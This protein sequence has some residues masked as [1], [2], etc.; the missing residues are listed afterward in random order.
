VP[1]TAAI[2]LVLGAAALF[3]AGGARSSE[4]SSTEDLVFLPMLVLTILGYATVGAILASRNPRH[5]IGWIMLTIGLAF[6]FSQIAESYAAYTLRIDRGALP[7]GSV[8]AWIGT[9]IY[10]VIFAALPLLALLYPSGGVVGPRW[11]IVVWLVLASASAAALG[12]ALAPGSIETE[13]GFAV[14]NPF[15]IEGLGRVLEIV[16]G[17]GWIGMM[18]GVP[19]AIASLVLRYRRSEGESRQQIRWLVSVAVAV[20]GALLITLVIFLLFGGDRFERSVGPQVAFAVVFGLIGVGVPTAMGVAILKYRL[21][22]L[23]LV[24]K[25]TILFAV[26]VLLLLAVSALGALLLGGTLVPSLTDRPA[27]L[28]V[29]GG[30]FGLLVIPA[31]RASRKIADRVV[32]GGRASPYEVL[33]EFTERAS[34]TYSTED[35][36]PRMAQ[37]IGQAT[38]AEAARVWL[39][40]GPE[41]RL[42]AAW[43]SDAVG[44]RSI[45]ALH[46]ELPALDDAYEIRHQGELLGALTLVMKPSDPMNPTKDRIVGDLVSQTGLVLRNVKLIEDLRESRRRIVAAQDERA[47]KLERN[48]HDGAQQQLVALAVKLGLVER[49]VATDPER[50]VSMLAEA[51]AEAND[52][53]DD[54]RDLARGI[55]PPLLA[56][57][58]LAAALEGQARKSPIRVEV[59]PDGIG[60]Y[61]QET[62]AAV[63]FSCLEALQN[64][65][66][67]AGATKATV[68]LAQAGGS[69]TFEVS[70]DGRGFDPAVVGH[71]SGLQGIA[72]RLAALG[73]EVTIRSAPGDGTTVAGRLPVEAAP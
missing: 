42:A 46:D 36:L 65:S 17:I 25:K 2:V 19:A 67:Y 71:G 39:H 23:D 24:I 5:P 51:K 41:L 32:Y 9:W 31:Y 6:A 11:R 10:A 35:V 4:G 30:T 22:D 73:G 49:F 64:V 62:E 13:T 7:F 63:Y 34:E 18:A 59:R 58:G 69:L 33:S 3:F 12:T 52:A 40:V 8:A 57:K 54:L 60:R 70:D 38:G 14:D 16:G 26:L 37:L 47:K 20:I 66:K 55:F 44:G 29:F 27:L 50:A 15:G 28:L 48:I 45:P 1:W 21:Y 53:L 61:P 72:D 43:P 68:R 56:D